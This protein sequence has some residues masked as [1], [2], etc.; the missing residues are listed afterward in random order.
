M[1]TETHKVKGE[2]HGAALESD[3]NALQA[4][5]AALQ[6]KYAALEA[7]YEALSRRL[8]TASEDS[9]PGGVGLAAAPKARRGG[10]SGL[11]TADAA[12][13]ACEITDFLPIEEHLTVDYEGLNTK[14]DLEDSLG[15]SWANVTLRLL[16]MEESGVSRMAISPV[17][18]GL[19]EMDLDTNSTDAKRELMRTVNTA[20][21]KDVEGSGGRMRG[22]CSVF[23]SDAKA[24]IDELQWCKNAGFPG[25]LINGAEVTKSTGP[26]G[27]P[28]LGYNYYYKDDA[29]FRECAR[30]NMFVYLHPKTLPSPPVGLYDQSTHSTPLGEE[31]VVD[32]YNFNETDEPWAVRPDGAFETGAPWGYGVHTADVAS[33][34]ILHGLF[35]RVPDLKMVLGHDG[36]M[37]AF[38]LWRIDNSMHS[39]MRGEAAL[40]GT[41]NVTETF[42]R[43]FYVTTSGFFDTPALMHLLA[44]M[45]SDRILFSADTPFEDLGIATSW[46][47]SIASSH[48]EI[49]CEVL[50]DIA[51]RNA[52]K[53]LGWK[54]VAAQ[55]ER[56]E[57]QRQAVPQ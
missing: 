14:G 32:A 27:D 34:L 9:A 21:V 20:I 47:R 56:T 24:A 19:Q 40:K 18:P 48:P 23:M 53:L 13:A 37:L 31:M 54:S 50:Q 11:R 49:S 30:L 46:F 29:I 12:A 28:I 52:E 35:D 33:H 41:V 57:A 16:Q 36:E 38:Q 17:P 1:G 39:M 51:Y 44:I 42:L 10:S 22:L 4:K 25:V 5:H 55:A 8:A 2:V 3:H 7:Q 6:A 45:P 26:H 43:N 15:A